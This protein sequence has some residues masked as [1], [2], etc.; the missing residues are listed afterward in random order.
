[1][2]GEVT[3]P[4]SIHSILVFFYRSSA[5]TPLHLRRLLFVSV[6]VCLRGSYI[7]ELILSSEVQS[8]I[9]T[10]AIKAFKSKECRTGIVLFLLTLDVS[11]NGQKASLMFIEQLDPLEDATFRNM[12]KFVKPQGKVSL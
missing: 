8:P 2:Y 3:L 1:M 12:Y 9:H 4:F 10:L 7:Q 5:S 11:E 6:Y